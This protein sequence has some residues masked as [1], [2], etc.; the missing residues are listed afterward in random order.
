M[1]ETKHKAIRGLNVLRRELNVLRKQPSAGALVARLL[2]LVPTDVRGPVRPAWLRR[3]MGWFPHVVLCVLAVVLFWLSW[4]LYES[5]PGVGSRWKSTL[6]GLAAGAP[7]TVVLFRPVTAWWLSLAGVCAV[8]AARLEV[9]PFP[10][11]ET[12]FASHLAVMALVALRARPV[13]VPVMWLWTTAVAYLAEHIFPPLN[14]VSNNA[15]DFAVWSAAVLTGVL[16]ARGVLKARDSV[17]SSRRDALAERSKRTVLE[18]RTT[19]A[20]EL[21]DV[22]AHH[23]S[24]IAIQAEAA[25][26][27]VESTPPELAASFTL[28]RENALAALAEL[29]RV[30]GIIRI[31]DYGTQDAP[32][33]PQPTLDVLDEL[34]AN[35]REAGLPVDKAVITGARRELPQGVELSAYRIIQEA[36]SNA[37]RHSPG[38]ATRVELSYVPGGLEVRVV[39]GPADP[40]AVRRVTAG[41]AR[42]SDGSGHGITGMRERVAMLEGEMTAGPLQDGGYEVAVFLPAPSVTEV[43]E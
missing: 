2:P 32:D 5:S 37:L 16:A 31:A 19:I 29:R 9:G 21:H 38:S 35:V 36:L 1:S 27:R 39:N 33:A 42:H 17:T 22:V 24:V 28:I 7:L 34:L 18:E 30:V 23:M 3:A 14:E 25:P 15:D 40:D 11:V 13:M 4:Y 41:G 12:L 8:V 20:R 26:Y 43:T 10:F 6:L